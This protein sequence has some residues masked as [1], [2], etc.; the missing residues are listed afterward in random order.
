MLEMFQIFL[1]KK[2]DA[3]IEMII[4]ISLLDEKSWE[5]EWFC[6][7]CEVVP[8]GKTATPSNY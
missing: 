3:M 7:K 4:S 2:I 1:V 5:W 8:V 6:L